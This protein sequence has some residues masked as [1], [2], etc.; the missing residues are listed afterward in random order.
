MNIT[1]ILFD[2]VARRPDALAIRYAAGELSYGQ[3]GA[4]VAGVASSLATAGVAA[5]EVVAIRL[6]DPLDHWTATL[7]LAYIGATV[8][9]IPRA[10][11]DVQ[12]ERLM[13]LTQC[14][15]VLAGTEYP[16]TGAIPSLPETRWSAILASSDGAHFEPRVTDPDQP[17]IYVSGSGSTGRPKIMPVSHAQQMS[18]SGMAADWVPYGSGDV[19]VSL[20]SMHFY[21]AKQRCLEAVMKGA[22][23][24]MGEVGRID[25]RNEVSAGTI[26]AIFSAV[27]HVERL[28]RLIHRDEGQCYG[29]LK[30]LLVG[31]STVSMRLRDEIRRRVTDNLYVLWGTNESH[32]ATMTRPL[33]VFK[34]L[35]GVGRFFPRFVVEIVDSQDQ[36]VAAGTDGQIRLT[37]PT[38][39]SGYLGDPEATR[40][41]F[42]HGWFY[43]GDIGHLTPDGQLVH[44]GRADDMM[45]VSG[46]NVYPSEVQECIR[47]FPGVAD[48]LVT[49]LR[50][51]QLQDQPVALVVALP[52]MATDAVQ[53]HALLQ[54]V[55]SQIGRHT[56]HDLVFVERIP[57]N[58]QGKVQ[59]EAIAEMVRSRWG[60][61]AIVA[62]PASTPEQTLPA[63]PGT[64]T[65]VFK[66]SPAALPGALK[67]WCALLDEQLLQT[68][69]EAD[70][71]APSVDG[72]A[73]GRAW[74]QDVLTLTLGLLHALR[75]PIFEPI[76][77]LSCHQVG[78]ASDRWQAACRMPDSALVPGALF[79]GVVKVAFKLAQ[80]LCA[81]DVRAPANRRHFFQTIASDVLRAFAK[82][83][84]SGKSTFEVL[85][86]AHRMGVPFMPLPGG[87]FQL[88]W[89]ERSRRIDRSTTDRDS[90]LGTQW[91]R[92]KLMSAALLRQ[93]GLPA[94]VHAQVDSLEQARQT[95]SRIGYPVV[96]KPADMER[97]EGVSVDVGAADLE[98]AFGDAHQRSPSK[99]VLV[100]RQVDGVCH[101]LFIA[102]GRLLYAVRRLPIGV[103]GD[104]RSTIEA[105]VAA[106]CD[107]QSRLPPWKR[108]RIRPLDE[109][110]LTML[111]RQRFDPDTVPQPGTFVALRRIE[112]TAWGGVDEEVT[113]TIHPD[114]ISA[115]VVAAQLFGLEVAGVDMISSNIREPWHSNGAIINEV[116]YAPLL[117]GGDISRRYIEEHLG[118][119]LEDRGRI[120]LHF[121]ADSEEA[122]LQARGHWDTLRAAGVRAYLIDA[123]HTLDPKGKPLAL[124]AADPHARLRALL[125]QKTVQAVVVA[126]SAPDL[127]D[128]FSRTWGLSSRPRPALLDA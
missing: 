9:S 19:L 73:P 122:R 23:I 29:N 76:A 96:V 72:T 67:P 37:S 17:W 16:A 75:V 74:L 42:R 63:P 116:N 56:L 18:R 85:R 20:V 124:A 34:T 10:M 39:I 69:D 111:R 52:G 32:T 49:P 77:L 78:P 6:D 94:P 81:A 46:V 38:L 58:G 25:F 70:T 43:P 95:A 125:M 121:Y 104:G 106:E 112:S 103:Y 62:R 44:R 100:E 91:A 7:A 8:V 60:V 31:G 128:K 99:T 114:N 64:I 53:T 54:H 83:R 35:D 51:P 45:I 90:A 24:F 120:P 107:V 21:S 108:S 27:S 102:A 66:L 126:S 48:A 40:K 89:G 109:M 93:A 22:G 30:A 12:R 117:G 28:L 50:H 3:F 110:A 88:G 61:Q 57:R 119:L 127:R 115:A 36:P 1:Q 101:R 118:R 80:Q 59:G 14:T 41:V 71:K 68:T 97:G 98:A 105:L 92:N 87:A 113:H 15:R 86:V 65:L 55:H 13:R 26:T 11:P 4:R 79:E 2:Q 5:K 33:E 47:S 82:T 84:P 123:P